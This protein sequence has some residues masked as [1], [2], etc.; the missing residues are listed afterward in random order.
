MGKVII[1]DYRSGYAT[2]V[3]VI[4][5]RALSGDVDESILKLLYFNRR[6]SANGNARVHLC[7]FTCW[8]RVSYKWDTLF[9]LC[10][11]SNL[12][13][14]KLEESSRLEPRIFHLAA[15]NRIACI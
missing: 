4:L 7:A 5:R 6:D 11:F 9:N 1:V 8:D 13:H 2:S 12:T 14:E 15:R 10:P 3:P